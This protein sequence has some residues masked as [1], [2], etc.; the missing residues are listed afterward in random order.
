MDR[1]KAFRRTCI[2]F[3]YQINSAFTI[4]DSLQGVLIL[5]NIVLIGFMGTGKT[6]VARRLARLLNKKFLDTDIEIER[7]TGIPINQLL[8][9]YGEKRFQSEESL[10]L[11]RISEADN[12][13]IATGCNIVFK[14]ENRELIKNMGKVVCLTAA[15]EKI[16]E[17]IEK[18]GHRH[19][20][21]EE[22][23]SLEIVKEMLTA[24]EKFYFEADIIINT[25]D[26]SVEEVV[27]AVYKKLTV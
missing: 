17:R 22:A 11:K 21:K 9:K 13:V 19:L 20:A 25:T 16:K 24:R 1:K 6:V 18:R 14:S 4:F 12:A 5:K 26:L 7:V 8:K 23:E 15:P 3:T 10:A 2:F 27:E